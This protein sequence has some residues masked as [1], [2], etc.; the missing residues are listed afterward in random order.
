LI[1]SFSSSAN[2]ASIWKMS[3]PAGVEVSMGSVALRNPGLRR[4]VSAGA[5]HPGT[6]SMR[7]LVRKLELSE[8]EMNRLARAFA[9]EEE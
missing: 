2:D 5:D 8:E 9:L 7:A 3:L 1:V 4:T 6:G